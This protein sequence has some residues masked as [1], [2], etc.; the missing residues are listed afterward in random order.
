MGAR[1]PSA[2]EPVATYRVTF[3]RRLR[4]SNPAAALPPQVPRV[5]RML[6]L[7][8]RIDG[9]IRAR[10]LR[11][12]ADAA[13]L[14]GVTRARMTQI[15]NLLLLAPL[16]QERVLTFEEAQATSERRL[17][18]VVARTEWSVQVRLWQENVRVGWYPAESI[19]RQVPSHDL[20]ALKPGARRL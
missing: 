12:W 9:M 2:A 20:K 14:L 19:P 11:D 4:A 16:M 15:S 17:R 7:A 1:R 6:V 3:K 8:H 5:T 13:R 18:S 10:D